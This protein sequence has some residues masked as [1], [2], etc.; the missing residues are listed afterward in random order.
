MEGRGREAGGSQCRVVEVGMVLMLLVMMVI[1]RRGVGG[2][3]GGDVLNVTGD[4][5]AGGLRGWRG[6]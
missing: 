5:A 6:G 4:A 2:Q 3:R 1:E